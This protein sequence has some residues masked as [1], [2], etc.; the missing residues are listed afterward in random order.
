MDHK[1]CVKC[2]KMISPQA[3]ICFECVTKETRKAMERETERVV[4]EVVGD[5]DHK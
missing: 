2:G 3:Q 1:H 4:S 5:K